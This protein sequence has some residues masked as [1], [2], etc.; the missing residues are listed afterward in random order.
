MTIGRTS[1]ILASG[2]VR[3]KAQSIRLMP[4]EARTL[5]VD[6]KGAVDAGL[7]IASA[8]FQLDVTGT[9]TISGGVISGL[10]ASCLLTG[11]RSGCV[12]GRCSVTMSDGSKLAQHFVVSV[13]MTDFDT[14]PQPGG[15]IDLTVTV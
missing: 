12:G 9:A 8:R 15:S 14:D 13:G 11:W 7:T 2:Y 5:A 10:V 1:K 6:V 3:D 4:T